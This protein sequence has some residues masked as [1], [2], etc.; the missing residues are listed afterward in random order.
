LVFNPLADG[1]LIRVFYHTQA[2]DG[3]YYDFIIND[4]SA[5]YNR[6]F[7]DPSTADAD[8]KINHVNDNIM[9]TIACAQCL[10]GDYAFIKLTGLEGFK[11]MM[12]IAINKA[13]ITFTT[14]LDGV[15]YKATT[16][17]S[18]IYLKYN[19]GDTVKYNVPDYVISASF[20]DGAFNSTT[21]TYSFNLAA[22][23]QEYLEGKIEKPEVEIYLPIGEYNNAILYS[24]GSK[25]PPTFT[26]VYTR[27]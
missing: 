23:V 18:R 8:K 3:L 9:D 11:S 22:F 27:F 16:I 5:R 1:F 17:P 13:R 15:T 21:S 7:H 26:L 25:H 4:K 2:K 12:P 14:F 19:S 6:Y 20:F 10:Y 24:V